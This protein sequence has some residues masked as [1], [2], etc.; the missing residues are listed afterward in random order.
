MTMLAT[1][2]CPHRSSGCTTLGFLTIL[3]WSHFKPPRTLPSREVEVEYFHKNALVGTILFSDSYVHLVPRA[4][5][6][7]ESLDS[8]QAFS[9]QPKEDIKLP[10][11]INF[12]G[13]FS[14]KT[15]ILGLSCSPLCGWDHHY[16]LCR[17]YVFIPGGGEWK[18]SLVGNVSTNTAAVFTLQTVGLNPAQH[19][20]QIANHPKCSL[21]SRITSFN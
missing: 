19:W 15:L 20:K 10:G 18:R 14:T 3:S 7:G 13:F 4:R 11:E 21:L 8:P 9:S 5:S 17:I 12:K 1:V 2:T 6:L 16:N